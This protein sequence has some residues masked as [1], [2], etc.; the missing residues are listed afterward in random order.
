[1]AARNYWV[2]T[3]RPDGRPHAMPVWGLWLAG[4]VAFST[5]P[6]SRKGRNLA[7]QPYAVVHLESGDDVVVTEGAVRALDDPELLRRFADDYERKYAFRPEPGAEGQACY[8]LQPSV[9]LAWREVDFPTTA[10]KWAFAA[11]AGG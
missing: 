10:T 1:M 5:D 2:C 3:T 6:A 7:A 11:G 8:L 9:V 4:G